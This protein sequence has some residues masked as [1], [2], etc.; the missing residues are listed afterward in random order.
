MRTY[1]HTCMHAYIPVYMSVLVSGPTAAQSL[2]ISSRA[3]GTESGIEA[4]E[5]SGAHPRMAVGAEIAAA[6]Y[7]D[8]GPFTALADQPCKSRLCGSSA[9]IAIR[10]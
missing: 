1:I 4:A 7:D 6:I 3:S 10:P 2:L 5:Y 9:A 8:S